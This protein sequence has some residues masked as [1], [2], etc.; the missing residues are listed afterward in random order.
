[1]SLPP[2]PRSWRA[3]VLL[4]WL[5]PACDRATPPATATAKPPAAEETPAAPAPE[6]RPK[7]EPSPKPS[8]QAD[9]SPAEPT[10]TVEYDSAAG[11]HYLERVVGGGEPDDA[12]PMIVAIHGLGDR[13]EAFA[14]ILDTFV[15]PAR[16][17][18]PRGIDEYEGGWSWFSTRARSEHVDQLGSELSVAAG[19]IATGVAAIA[20]ARPTRGKPIVTG[21]S[22]GGM[23]AF[24]LALHHPDVFAASVPVGGWLPPPL[25]PKTGPGDRAFPPVVA[26]HGTAD[27]AVRYD[28]TKLAVDSLAE[29]GYPVTLRTFEGVPHAIPPIVHRELL[30]LIQD[31]V[32]KAARAKPSAKAPGKEAP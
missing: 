24:T 20:D 6:P 26:L 12:L 31:S 27:A 1:M 4:L 22:Q 13:P 9:E 5:G 18:L 32:R 2:F 10:P 29:L 19:V 28:G 8:T 7:A 11:L 3:L 25:W 30:D 16:V 17:I 21:F 23:L 15:E 14:R